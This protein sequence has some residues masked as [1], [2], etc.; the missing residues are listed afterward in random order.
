[1]FF[2]LV[3]DCS[4]GGPTGG[5]SFL[6]LI[7]IVIEVCHLFTSVD[8]FNRN[9]IFLSNGYLENILII[10]P[11]EYLSCILMDYAKLY[12]NITYYHHMLMYIGC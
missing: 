2:P 7:C 5:I 8:Y 3:E 12:S 11:W 1:M 6:V 4:G 10:I 9:T